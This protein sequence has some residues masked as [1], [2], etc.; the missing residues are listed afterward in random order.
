MH[1]IFDGSSNHTA[2]TL[3]GL[4][5]CGGPGGMTERS[6]GPVLVSKVCHFLKGSMCVPLLRAYSSL[7][8]GA[9]QEQ[10][11]RSKLTSPITARDVM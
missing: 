6:T 1:A 2:R 3:D 9:Y 8:V 10:A 4:H 11:H 5:V 7:V